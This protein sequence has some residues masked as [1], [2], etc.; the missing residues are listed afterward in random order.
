VSTAGTTRAGDWH[1]PKCQDL[2]FSRNDTCR[3]CGTA[4]PLWLGAD[5]SL[6]P[7]SY[8]GTTVPGRGWSVVPVG[9]EEMAAF[10]EGFVMGGTLGGR[11]HRTALDYT[12]FTPYCA[13][14]LQH[15]G[16]WGKYAM[17][18][19]N[20]AKMELPLLRTDGV[21][22]SDPRLRQPFKDM[23][24]MLPGSLDCNLNEVYL[25]HGSKPESILAILSGGLNERFSG[26]LFGNGTYLAEDVGKNDQYCTY[27]EGHGAHP[28]LHKLLFDSPGVEH[29][30]KLLY[31]FVCRVVLGHAIRTKDGRTDLED[32]SHR[33]IWS[34]VGLPVIASLSFFMATGY[35]Q[36]TWLH[37]N[38]P[39]DLGVK[40]T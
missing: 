36:N 5:T 18:R 14:R 32:A 7:P 2:Q 4:R 19:E 22:L 29:P 38:A 28:E 26:G 10:Q 16:L 12:G 30:G 40:D 31:V 13:W 15:P 27:D 3:Q 21:R 8:W 23:A 9:A 24:V 11:D 34:A 33:S 35:T 39:R 17:E 20:L 1:C 6:R 37:T 25:S